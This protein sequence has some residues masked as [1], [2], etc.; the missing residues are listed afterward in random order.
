MASKRFNQHDITQ[1]ANAVT[2]EFL[3]L[4]GPA[5][6]DR[7]NALARSIYDLAFGHTIKK[8]K[9]PTSF[10]A[11]TTGIPVCV[12]P[13]RKTPKRCVLQFSGHTLWNNFNIPAFADSDKP[14]FRKIEYRPMPYPLARILTSGSTYW[15]ELD[16]PEYSDLSDAINLTSSHDKF[17]DVLQLLGDQEAFDAECKRLRESM[18]DLAR[19]CGT[20]DKLLQALSDHGL[21]QYSHFVPSAAPASGGSLAVRLDTLIKP[22]QALAQAA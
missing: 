17:E 6:L 7:T 3:N 1:F 14:A 13:H 22:L 8:S 5:L 10:F 15:D 20:K 19:A 11:T 21:E 18:R 4:R 12:R 2:V 16:R 9:L